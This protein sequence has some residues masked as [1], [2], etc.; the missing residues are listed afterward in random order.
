[1]STL[2]MVWALASFEVFMFAMH[3]T[4]LKDAFHPNY[5]TL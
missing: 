5:H 4:A 3:W 2:N 1:M